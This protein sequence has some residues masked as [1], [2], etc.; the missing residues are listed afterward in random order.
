VSVSPKVLHLWACIRL[1]HVCTHTHTDTHIT[2]DFLLFILRLDHA[3]SRQCNTIN[4]VS[5][6]KEGAQ[7][8]DA[9]H[10]TG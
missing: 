3:V 7:R 8:Q 4:R 5:M 2:E 10:A 1:L 9:M 6:V